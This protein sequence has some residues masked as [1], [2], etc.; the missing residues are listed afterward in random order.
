MLIVFSLD[1]DY[2]QA[3]SSQEELE[4]VLIMKGNEPNALLFNLKRS[5]D[6]TEQQLKPALAASLFKDR[7]I[8]LGAA[9]KNQWFKFVGIYRTFKPA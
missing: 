5:F 1:A 3:D 8:S 7:V 4:P 6:Y 2:T 9:A